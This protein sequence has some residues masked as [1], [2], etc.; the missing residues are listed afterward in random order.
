MVDM[1]AHGLDI[2]GNFTEFWLPA[3][4]FSVLVVFVLVQ[5]L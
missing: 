4:R 1:A 2:L 3:K 5:G